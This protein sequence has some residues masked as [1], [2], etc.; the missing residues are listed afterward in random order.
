MIKTKKFWV[1]IIFILIVVVI[2]IVYLSQSKTKPVIQKT[3]PSPSIPA[4]YKGKL[5]IGWNISKENFNFPT[6]VPALEITPKEITLSMAQNIATAAGFTGSPITAQDTIDGT[7]YI[8]TKDSA[9]LIITPKNQKIAYD[10]NGQVKTINKQIDDES[11]KVIAENFLTQNMLLPKDSY[12]FSSFLYLKETSSQQGINPATKNEAEIT[13]VNFS[14]K[15]A[16][17]PIFSLNPKNTTAFTQIL[18]DGTV[19]RSQIILFGNLKPTIETYKIKN[20]TETG[21]SFGSA[22]L[23]S[24]NDG[25]INLPDIPTGNIGK[26][27]ITNI[28][29]VYLFDSPNKTILSPVYLLSGTTDVQGYG[30]SINALLYLPAIK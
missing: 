26:I 13:Q 30:S 14:P 7:T 29:L 3:L 24:L 1:F 25:N 12:S 28:S 18:K 10:S 2:V 21:E 27:T 22:T 4:N 19:F 6:S 8:W 9:S 11:L 23:V 20:Y 16:Q 15:N 17:F 5:Q